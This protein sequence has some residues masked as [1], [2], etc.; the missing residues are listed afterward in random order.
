MA[1]SWFEGGRRLRL[2]GAEVEVLDRLVDSSDQQQHHSKHLLHGASK[3]GK[4][5]GESAFY[6]IRVPPTP[7]GGDAYP[8]PPPG[9]LSDWIPDQPG[10]RNDP[11]P[12]RS[13]VGRP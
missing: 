11:Q 8:A 1:V 10:K 13:G 5:V 12:E 4:I 9:F 7:S 6:A 3:L 2:A